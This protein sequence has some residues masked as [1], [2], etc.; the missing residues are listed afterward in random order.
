MRFSKAIVHQL[1]GDTLT[2]RLNTHFSSHGM[3]IVIGTHLT[4]I[5]RITA[6]RDYKQIG[7][8]KTGKVWY[9]TWASAVYEIHPHAHTDGVVF[10]AYK[11]TYNYAD[12]TV[13][14]VVA[15]YLAS[16]RQTAQAWADTLCDIDTDPW[17]NTPEAYADHASN[18]KRLKELHELEKQQD[19]YR[20]Y[21]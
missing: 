11:F 19:R 17:D 4:P 1:Q 5:E 10:I 8:D 16:D 14:S 3:F 20:I 13:G 9:K 12:D 2:T 7:W 21:I 18:M 15:R 6:M